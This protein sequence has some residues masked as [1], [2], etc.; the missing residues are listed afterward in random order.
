MEFVVPMA[1]LKGN[2]NVNMTIF[3]LLFRMASVATNDDW[4]LVEN[5]R[6]RRIKKHRK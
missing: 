2:Y 6:K 5:E 3:L 4:Q 1:H